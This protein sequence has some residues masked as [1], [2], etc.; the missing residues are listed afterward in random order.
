M[1]GMEKIRIAVSRF[2]ALDDEEWERFAALFE[3]RHL[4]KGEFLIRGGQVEDHIYFLAT[5]ST[6]SYFLQDG[7]EITVD[8]HFEGEFVTAYFSL[9]TR[10]PTATW[11]ILLQDSEV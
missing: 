8:F 7:K 1:E 5:G 9:I 11:I 3:T 2:S 10:E 4:E 6:R